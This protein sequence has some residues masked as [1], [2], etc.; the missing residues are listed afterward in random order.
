MDKDEKKQFE[1]F[2]KKKAEQEKIRKLRNEKSTLFKKIE[3][4][5]EEITALEP[6]RRVTTY[7]DPYVRIE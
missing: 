3:K 2:K 4:I 6:E 5:D 1:E 7:G